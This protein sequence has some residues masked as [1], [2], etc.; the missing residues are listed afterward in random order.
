MI[1][2]KFRP[3]GLVLDLHEAAGLAR[4]KL[5]KGFLKFREQRQK[6]HDFNP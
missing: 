4:V 6:H 1:G 2:H 5:R 3:Q